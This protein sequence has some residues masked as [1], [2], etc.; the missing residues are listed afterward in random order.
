M[1]DYSAGT[2]CAAFNDSS[3]D[4][5]RPDESVAELHPELGQCL[6]AY[7]GDVSRNGSW[8]MSLIMGVVVCF[9]LTG[10]MIHNDGL[11]PKDQGLAIG[12]LV[13]G[14]LGV[15]C[16]ALLVRA[17]R[18]ANSDLLI[19]ENGLIAR[20]GKQLD[21]LH[22]DAVQ[23]VFES[24]SITTYNGGVATQV[25][26]HLRFCLDDV[27]EV[28][29]DL[30]SIGDS[31][32]AS[33]I[34]ANL[35]VPRLVQRT[36]EKI[37]SGQAADFGC[38]KLHRD[39]LAKANDPAG[40]VLGWRDI[41]EYSFDDGCVTVKSLKGWKTWVSGSLDK[42]PN[43]RVLAAF[44]EHYRDGVPLLGIE[45]VSQPSELVAG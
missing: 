3:P 15:G 13:M 2:G 6:A 19:F 27:R 21:K 28:K 10:Y 41:A 25:K 33:G 16:V 14:L 4:H 12:Q 22:W 45:D 29:L 5:V 42:T 39:G 24:M 11:W 43:F 26:H 31:E 23:S 17:I 8:L 18:K 37:E 1:N 30:S 35:T 34:I 20:R 32:E 9:G 44:L 7:R 36:R 38:I 40:N